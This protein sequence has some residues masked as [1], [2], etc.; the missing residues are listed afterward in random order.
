ML[1]TKT[2]EGAVFALV[3]CNNFFVSCERLFQ[4]KLNRVPVVVLSNNDGCAVARSNEVKALGMPMGAPYFQWKQILTKHR[5]GVFSANFTLYGDISDRVVELLK[6]YSPRTE[7]YSIDESF[8]RIDGLGIEDYDLWAKNLAVDVERNIGIPVSV[9]VASTKTLAKIATERAKKVEGYMGGCSL[10]VNE[11]HNRLEQEKNVI[12]VLEYTP[13]EDVWGIG[14]R[15]AEKLKRIGLSTAYD[16]S[17]LSDRWVLENMTIV[18]LRTVRE[19]RGESCIPLDN[20]ALD[21]QQKMVSATRTFGNRVRSRAELESAVASFCARAGMRLRRKDQLAWSGSLFLRA[22]TLDGS[23]Q[24][25]STDFRLKTPSA[26]T[27]EI[28]AVAHDAL[29]SLHDSDF[30]YDKGGIILNSLVDKRAQQMSIFGGAGQEEIFRKQ[31]KLMGAM[32][33]LSLRYGKGSVS[34]GS[35]KM[36]GKWQSKRKK[37]SPAYTARWDQVPLVKG[38]IA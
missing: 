14:R 38:G 13:L 8:M 24:I 21:Y 3:D 9:G 29:E 22:K 15:F 7:V 6:T 16:V 18:G 4:P 10:V 17:N 2:D 11:T 37:V 12:K 25:I 32:D 27:G 26:F 1:D 35:E 33:R 5:T 20:F 23:K 19:L 30:S 31:D 36:A 28:I 34:F